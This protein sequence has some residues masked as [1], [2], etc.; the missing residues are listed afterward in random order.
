MT[1]WIRNSESYNPLPS[2]DRNSFSHS[3]LSIWGVEWSIIIKVS[4]TV[5]WRRNIVNKPF[6]PKHSILVSWWNDIGYS[7]TR[8]G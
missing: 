5:E 2:N 1:E 3:F 7:E 6:T 8:L 4:I